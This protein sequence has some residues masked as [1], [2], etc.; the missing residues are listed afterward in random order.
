MHAQ[1][2]TKREGYRNSE[3]LER[4]ESEIRRGREREGRERERKRDR[5]KEKIH[6]PYTKSNQKQVD[7][8]P[9]DPQYIITEL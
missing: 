7:I 5:E 2:D 6:N 4:R 3:R 8:F 1:K 9:I